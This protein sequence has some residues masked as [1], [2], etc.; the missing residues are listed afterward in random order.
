MKRLI[1]FMIYG[2]E[3]AFFAVGGAVTWVFECFSRIWKRIK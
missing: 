3:I 1:G 2:P